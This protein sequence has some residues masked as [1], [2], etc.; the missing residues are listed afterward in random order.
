MIKDNF[1]DTDFTESFRKW[2]VSVLKSPKL[3]GVQK[4]GSF[5]RIKNQEQSREK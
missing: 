3:P 1:D 2:I 4:A 5:C